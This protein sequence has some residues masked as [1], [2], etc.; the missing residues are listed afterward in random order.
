MKLDYIII[1]GISIMALMGFTVVFFVVLHQ[2]RV[3]RHQVELQEIESQ[4]QM[5]LL[6]ASLQS[7]EEER[8]RI[9]AELHDDIGATLASARLYLHQAEKTATD[10]AMI[11][12]SGKLVDDSIR[13]VREVSHKLQPATLE[14]L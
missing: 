14:A 5:E 2:R 9:A 8:R 3:I 7:E 12:Q 10:A 1:I 6:Q 11:Q 4:R 13:K